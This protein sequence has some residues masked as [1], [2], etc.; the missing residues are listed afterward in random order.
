MRAYFLWLAKFLTVIVVFFFVV[1]FLIIMAA[2]AVAHAPGA[3]GPHVSKNSVAVVELSGMISDSKEVLEDLYEQAE[4]DHVQGIVLRIDSPG[5]AVGPSQE[6]FSAVRSLKAKKPIVASMGAVAASG[7][8]YSALGASRILCQPGTLTGSIGVIFQVP[9]FSKIAEKVGVDFVTVKSGKLK[10]VGNTFRP[11]TDEEREFLQGTVSEAYEDFV[12][13]VSESRGLE[14]GKVREFADGRVLLGS[15]A[16]ELKLVDGYGDVMDA[17][18][19]VFELAGKPLE[20]DKMPK[21][22]YTKDKFQKFAKMIGSSLGLGSLISD[23]PSLQ[24]VM[25]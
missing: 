20:A 21:V 17:A 19:L 18:R 24:Y 16:K 7:G 23:Q 11:M 13:A 25:N 9:N 2:A 3:A 8:L 15:Q 1:P 22:F 14:I 10:D 12:K 6:I 5:G 4:D